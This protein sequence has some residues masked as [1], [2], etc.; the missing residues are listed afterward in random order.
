MLTKITLQCL[1]YTQ[2]DRLGSVIAYSK[3]FNDIKISEEEIE[4]TFDEVNG[5]TEY[6]FGIW[7]R[8]LFNYP[9]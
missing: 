9:K 6:G 4:M 5:V 3:E 8:W 1:V 7:T 2:C